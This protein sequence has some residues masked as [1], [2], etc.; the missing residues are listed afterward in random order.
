ME[1]KKERSSKSNKQLLLEY[2]GFAFTLMASAGIATY[3]GLKLD[4]R[5]QPGFPL[6]VWLLPF[7]VIVFLIIK[8]I[9]DTSK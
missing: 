9:K 1:N 3:A 7:V 5:I 4:D 8:A 6:F 2:S